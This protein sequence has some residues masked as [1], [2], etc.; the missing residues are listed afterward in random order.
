MQRTFVFTTLDAVIYDKS[1]KAVK[2]VPVRFTYSELNNTDDKLA[3][4]AAKILGVP[5]MVVDNVKKV[6][7]LRVM[8]DDKFYELSKLEKTDIE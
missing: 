1:T 6:S 8:D 2:T 7:E 4:R 3:R 5:V